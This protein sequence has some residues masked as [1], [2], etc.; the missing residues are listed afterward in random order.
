MGLINID[1]LTAFY[2]KIKNVFQ[3]RKNLDT[4]GTSTSTDQAAA[5]STISQEA[6]VN[7]FYPIGSIYMSISSINPGTIM[8][9][10]WELWGSGRTPLG[11]DSSDSDFSTVSKTGGAKTNTVSHTHTIASHSHNTAAHT[12]TMNGH[13]HTIASHTHGAGTLSAAIGA[14]DDNSLKLGY[15]YTAAPSGLSTTQNVFAFYELH[16]SAS[17]CT[18]WNHGTVV[19]GTSAGSG[20]LTTGSTTETMSSASPTTNNSSATTDSTSIALSTIQ[21][22]IV[23]YMWKR[24]A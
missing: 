12:H 24:T 16:S 13:T 14:V 20:S 10:T 7:K 22:Y 19:Y 2:N 1:N 11:V 6:F 21:P 23:C 8:G 18:K 15:V 5:A 17:S 9:G 3:M 4:T